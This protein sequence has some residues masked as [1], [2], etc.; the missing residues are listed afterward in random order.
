[1][2]EFYKIILD[3][4]YIFCL[5]IALLLIIMILLLYLVRVNK[6][7]KDEIEEE[8]ANLKS[9]SE[10]EKMSDAEIEKRVIAEAIE[11]EKQT[12][13]KLEEIENNNKGNTAIEEIIDSLKEATPNKS[14]EAL[15][16]F[17]E[18]QEEN[19]II[20]YQ[21][22]VKAVNNDS[23]NDY[24]KDSVSG[25]SLEETIKLLDKYENLNEEVNN[26][27]I[28][29]KDYSYKPNEFISPVFGRMD[30]SNVHYREGL[31]Y[32]D[33][34][35]EKNDLKEQQ[36]TYEKPAHADVLF[37]YPDDNSFK[38]PKLDSEEFLR[39]LKEFRNNL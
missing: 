7:R 1:M 17:E 5:I 27:P 15:R 35:E 11:D 19:A 36:V 8:R 23:N 4:I 28:V 34:K 31:S 32:T 39:N 22:L 16:K 33:K 29:T 10:L 24:V 13:E 14:S 3:N 37:D 6:H 38:V 12:Q 20:S 21:Q 30:S 26:E 9:K 2:E 25:E 18:E